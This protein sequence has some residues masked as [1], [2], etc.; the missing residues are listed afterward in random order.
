MARLV[1]NVDR[2]S[3]QGQRLHYVERRYEWGA[4]VP[5]S[6]AQFATSSFAYGKAMDRAVSGSPVRKQLSLRKDV[7][8]GQSKAASNSDVGTGILHL[9]V[10][11]LHHPKVVAMLRVPFPLPDVEVCGGGDQGCG[12]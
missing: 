6:F 3:A 9:K 7:E 8:N 11:T 12:V 5:C 4:C 10:G 2:V 1:F